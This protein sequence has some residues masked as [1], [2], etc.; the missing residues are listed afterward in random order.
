[1][2]KT[3][4]FALC[5][6]AISSVAALGQALPTASRIGDLQVGAGYSNANPDYSPHRFN[7]FL[8]YGTFD[9]RSR[10]GVELN[11]HHVSGPSS[12]GTL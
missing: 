5:F 10:L 7:G 12:E 1:M 8:V 4:F 11:F 2:H 3:T 9:F 6:F